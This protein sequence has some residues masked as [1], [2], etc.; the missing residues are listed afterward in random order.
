[1]DFLKLAWEYEWITLDE[2]KTLVITKATPWGQITPDEFKE[3][4]GQDFKE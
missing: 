3:I 4:P 2:L 1:M